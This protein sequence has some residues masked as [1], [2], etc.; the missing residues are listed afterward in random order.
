MYQLNSS[1]INSF[2]VTNINQPIQMPRQKSK[3][4]LQNFNL[5]PSIPPSIDEHQLRQERISTRLFLFL[6][7]SSLT[8]L[9][10]YTSLINVTQ[11]VSV[12]GPTIIQ[13]SQLYS[14]YSQTLTCPCSK[15]SINYNTFIQINYTLHQVCNSIFVTKYWIDYLATSIG[16]AITYFDD[17][18]TTGT[19]TF[20]AL[21]AF[22]ELINQTIVNRLI[23]F[24]STQYVSASVTSPQL[25]QLQTQSFISQFISTMTNDFL[26]SLSTIRDTT[27]SNGLLSGTASNYIIYTL[28][29]QIYAYTYT[30][31]YGNCICIYSSMCASQCNIYDYPNYTVLF[32]VPGIYTGCYVIESLLQS[33]LECFYNQTCINK[34]QSYFA[35]SSSMNITALDTSLSSRYLENSTIEDLLDQLMVEEWN[36]SIIYENYFNE[37]EPIECTYNQQTKNS[38]IYIVTTIIGLNGGLIT[39]LKLIVPRL[40]KFA[41]RKKETAAS[42]TGKI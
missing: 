37:C 42:E 2:Q 39:V 5:F 7:I 36:S 29:G 23:E 20:Q 12:K 22:C 25:F 4:F 6:L 27:Q 31:V 17:F 30:R 9:L 15:I 1:F 21:S 26:L 32:P 38:I 10:L 40:V 24:Y 34:L 3:V 8:I 41:R 18:R 19:L 35:Y 33:N 28:S 16:S 11:T 13:Y 14:T